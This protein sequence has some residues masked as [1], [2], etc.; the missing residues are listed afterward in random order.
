MSLND[1]APRGGLVAVTTFLIDILVAHF[2]EDDVI[3]ITLIV[4][5]EGDDGA[6]L[7]SLFQQVGRLHNGFWRR[8][9]V[10]LAKNGFHD[11]VARGHTHG[12]AHQRGHHH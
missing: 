11:L 6:L 12:A 9:L 4:K 5:P 2:L 7:L 3:E 8:G 10:P 1:T